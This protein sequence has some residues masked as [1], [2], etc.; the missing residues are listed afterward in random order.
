VASLEAYSH[1]ATFSLL[2][3][4]LQL[5]SPS[6]SLPLM[7]IDHALSHL[8][9]AHTLT[10]VI[11]SI[12]HNAARRTFVVPGDMASSNSLSE[13]D[14]FRRGGGATGIRDAVWEMHE[15]AK[16]ELAKAKEAIENG[17]GGKGMPREVMPV[18]LVAVSHPPPPGYDP[19]W[20]PR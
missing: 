14:L 2:S 12:P 6:P 17:S 3:L 4:Q 1:S 18:F 9:I 20:R 11:R 13:E 10:L 8:C 19:G 16:D 5:L 7:A 15:I